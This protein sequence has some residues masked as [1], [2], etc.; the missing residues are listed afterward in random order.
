MHYLSKKF[1]IRNDNIICGFNEKLGTD[2][3]L[4]ISGKRTTKVLDCSRRLIC[5]C[6]GAILFVLSP[7]LKSDSPCALA[8][9]SV[10]GRSIES[11]FFVISSNFIILQEN[12]FIF[13]N[14]LLHIET[15][16]Q[17]IN[18]E[19]SFPQE[20]LDKKYEIALIKL[21]GILEINKKIHINHTNNKFYYLVKTDSF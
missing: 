8:D 11:C 15:I 3:A 9:K 4:F 18:F 20:F 13:I 19:Y 10:A 2:K 7:C 6:P 16:I 12:I 14:G 21:D 5:Y 1:A 17:W